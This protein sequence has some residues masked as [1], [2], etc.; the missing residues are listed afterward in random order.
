M[1]IF[2]LKETEYGI[3]VDT[4]PFNRPNGDMHAYQQYLQDSNQVRTSTPT[5]TAVV[6][7]VCRSASVNHAQPQGSCQNLRISGHSKHKQTVNRPNTANVYKS[8]S[9]AGTRFTPSLD[10]P[11]GNL[12]SLLNCLHR[13]AKLKPRPFSALVSSQH[14]VD[15]N[16]NEDSQHTDSEVSSKDEH[17]LEKAQLSAQQKD[18]ILASAINIGDRVTFSIPQKPPRYG[19]KKSEFVELSG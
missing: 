16:S 3:S 2:F 19:K 1:S 6:R 13:P 17:L 15:L 9:Y 8:D 12:N 14:V 11:L 10:Y 4:V 5:Q 7:P 18:E